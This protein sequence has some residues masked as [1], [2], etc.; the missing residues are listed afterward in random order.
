[1][2]ETLYPAR[3]W[4][5]SPLAVADG[6]CW[7]HKSLF[8]FLRAPFWGCS[9]SLGALP[10]PCHGHGW[11]RAQSPRT[12]TVTPFSP[13][14]ISR[15]SR[16]RRCLRGYHRRSLP[17]PGT[18]LTGLQGPPQPPYLP[19]P[20]SAGDKPGSLAR[21]IVRDPLV[22]KELGLKNV[23]LGTLQDP[24]LLVPGCVRSDPEFPSSVVGRSW[25]QPCAMGA[26]TAGLSSGGGG[27]G[28][29]Q[30]NQRRWV[31]CSGQQVFC[32][33]CDL[34]G[35][36]GEGSGFR[37]K[38]GAGSEAPSPSCCLLES[39]TPGCFIAGFLNTKGLT[40]GDPER[41][42]PGAGFALVTRNAEDVWSP[43]PAPFPPASWAA[44]PRQILGVNY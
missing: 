9:L 18:W 14:F 3:M 40:L 13:G 8:R 6:L 42:C 19:Q 27:Q 20:C 35:F 37:V 15:S 29:P 36:L 38:L 2:W 39:C 7:A 32:R 4:D 25:C 24:T 16:S 26:V 21:G 33:S 44:R 12:G 30:Q 17:A 41:G 11:Q 22:F 10:F 5:E 43:P 34:G 31:P 23:I 28:E 1:M